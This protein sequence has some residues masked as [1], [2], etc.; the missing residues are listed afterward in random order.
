M[1]LM[2]STIQFTSLF[3]LGIRTNRFN[4]ILVSNTRCSFLMWGSLFELAQ[5]DIIVG[6]WYEMLYSAVV[7]D[8]A[9]VEL[10]HYCSRFAGTLSNWCMREKQPTIPAKSNACLRLSLDELLPL[11][12]LSPLWR[13]QTRLL[14]RQTLLIHDRK[15]TE[16]HTW[17]AVVLYHC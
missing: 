5:R 13:I 2:V 15:Q 4:I 1:L 11:G 10:L 17:Y 12:A 8:L 3:P 9:S 7:V 16:P 6:D 14:F